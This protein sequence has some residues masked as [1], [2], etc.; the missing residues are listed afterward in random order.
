MAVGLLKAF[1]ESIKLLFSAHLY[2]EFEDARHDINLKVRYNRAWRDDEFDFRFKLKDG[3]IG[4]IYCPFLSKGKIAVN[5][6]KKRIGIIT[7]EG[8]YIYDKHV[9]IYKS[10]GKISWIYNGYEFT[11]EKDA[12]YRQG[13]KIGKFEIKCMAFLFADLYVQINDQKELVILTSILFLF[14]RKNMTIRWI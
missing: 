8:F 11:L 2:H 1:N 14:N 7:N 12:I 4:I 13:I 5:I 6:N 9:S 3:T 10:D